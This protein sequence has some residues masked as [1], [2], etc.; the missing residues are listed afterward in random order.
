MMAVDFV[1]KYG[2][3]REHRSDR[4]TKNPNNDVLII[5]IVDTYLCVRKMN[6][7]HALSK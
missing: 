6:G 2:I 4:N 7:S 3:L 1:S 5:W